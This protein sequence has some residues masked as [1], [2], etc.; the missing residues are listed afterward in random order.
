MNM[1]NRKSDVRTGFLRQRRNLFIISF[2]LLLFQIIGLKLEKV[3]FLGNEFRVS[4]PELLPACL[5]IVYLYYVV[6]YYQYF[7][8][9][10]DRGVRGKYS[11]RL[12]HLLDVTVVAKAKREFATGHKKENGAKYEFGQPEFG[13][14][15]VD[16]W[17][18]MVDVTVPVKINSVKS[19]TGSMSFTTTSDTIKST[20][21]VYWREFLR[22][23]VQAFLHVCFRTSL[24]TE[25]YLPFLVASSPCLWWLVTMVV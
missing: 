6:R 7:H 4:R 12:R 25:Y 11:G 13:N 15:V 5:W 21:T 20:E 22:F 2:G 14:I 18:A 10:Q 1:E 9:V 24:V 23:R 17:A 3:S 19:D 16:R 8:D